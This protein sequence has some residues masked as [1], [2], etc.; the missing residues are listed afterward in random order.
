MTS[1]LL[2][3]PENIEKNQPKKRFLFNFPLDFRQIDTSF[4]P[5]VHV[6]HSTALQND[7]SRRGRI[8]HAA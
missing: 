6:V 4:H 7:S 8:D 2:S 3:Q 1:K 5:H